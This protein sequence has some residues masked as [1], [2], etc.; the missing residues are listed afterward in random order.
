MALP[1]DV[2]ERT[3]RGDDGLILARSR[4]AIFLA[5]GAN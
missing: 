4:Y 2:F 5:T 1:L 3:A